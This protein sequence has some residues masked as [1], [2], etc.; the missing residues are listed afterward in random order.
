MQMICHKLTV[1]TLL[2][3]PTFN[4]HLVTCFRMAGVVS[5][6]AVLWSAECRAVRAKPIFVAQLASIRD[7][8]GVVASGIIFRDTSYGAVS[9]IPVLVT[10]L[11]SV[12]WPAII[13][14]LGVIP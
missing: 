6:I 9:T 13:M 3:F 14:S 2:S 4:A 10:N 7:I 1:K 11:R 12:Y 8:T 5:L